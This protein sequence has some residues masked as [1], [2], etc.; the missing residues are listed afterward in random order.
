MVVI[1]SILD[2][3]YYGWRDGVT[4]TPETCGEILAVC[5]YLLVRSNVAGMIT[6]KLLNI[7]LYKSDDVSSAHEIIITMRPQILANAYLLKCVDKYTPNTIEVILNTAKDREHTWSAVAKIIGICD[8]ATTFELFKKH[9]FLFDILFWDD[10][11]YGPAVRIIKELTNIDDINY[12][13]N[14]LIE[15]LKHN[16]EGDG[17]MKLTENLFSNLANKIRVFSAQ[18]SVCKLLGR[19]G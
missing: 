3:L 15:N 2:L 9:R 19:T 8:D 5:D 18:K 11:G 4:I 10:N 7:T 1:Q 13:Y 17:G 12:I 14:V 16:G 6:E